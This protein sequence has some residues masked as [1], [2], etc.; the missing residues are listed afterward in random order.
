MLGKLMRRT[1]KFLLYFEEWSLFLIVMAA[2]LSLFANVVL[3]YGFNYS[4]AWSE[5]LVREVITFS[6]FIGCSLA[7]RNRSMIKIDALVQIF[8]LLKTPFAYLSNI[9]VIVFSC[10]MIYYGWK[11]MELQILTGQTTII[12]KI[13]WSYLYAILP[14]SGAMMIFRT[15]HIMWTDFTQHV[16]K[17]ST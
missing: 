8:P 9:M 4:L 13:P 6:T 1:D 12:L 15:V 16:A 5:E 10:M 14:L 3:R 11:M 7:I 17:P 2:L